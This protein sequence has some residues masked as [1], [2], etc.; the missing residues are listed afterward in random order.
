MAFRDAE[1]IVY[2]GYTLAT[3]K[4]AKDSEKIDAKA[5]AKQYPDLVKKFTTTTPGS[6][7]FL[8]K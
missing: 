6:R 5:M 8:L 3:W 7:R 1:A 4:T 2:N